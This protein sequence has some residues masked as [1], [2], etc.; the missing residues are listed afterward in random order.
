MALTMTVPVG[1]FGAIDGS[2]IAVPGVTEKGYVDTR[3]TVSTAGG[4]SSVPP[5]HTVSSSDQC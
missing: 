2:I 3:V 5:P 4:H 1:V